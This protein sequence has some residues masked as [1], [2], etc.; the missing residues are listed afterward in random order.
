M[1][2][3]TITPR[4]R[5]DRTLSF[6]GVDRA[7][8]MEIAL[9]EQT[10]ERWKAEGLPESAASADLLAGSAHFGLEGYDSVLFNTTFPEPCP[11]E[12]V[13]S[14]DERYVTFVDGMGR[15]R[16]ALKSGTVRGM[17][18]SMDS[19]VGFP[20][21]SREDWPRLRA[22][23]EANPAARVPAGWPAL[24]ARLR[25]ASRPTT[26]FDRYFATFGCYSMMRNWMGTEGV[27]YMLYDDPALV[28]ECLGFLVDLL[29]RFL[30][31]PL[32]DAGFDLYYIHEDMAGTQGPLVS[33][34]LFREI[35]LPP[36]R[37][38]VDLLKKGGVK[39]VIVDTDGCFGPLIPVFLDAGVDGFGPI[40]RAAGMD[41]R[42]LRARYGKGFSMIGGI[43]KRILKKGRR[44]MEKEITELLPPLLEQGGYIPTIDHSIPPDISL[45]QFEAYLAVKRRAVFGRP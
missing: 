7:P 17:R 3:D 22:L 16:V 33:P 24:A 13:V 20:I 27:S 35:F 43:D 12:T 2:A 14:E 26:F 4:E 18:L 19:Y 45:A 21:R 38:L 39:N 31:G 32:A 42:E 8:F 9:W 30:P 6:Q 28:R 25:A 1:S 36:Y 15:T 44:D 34:E 37:R 5:L 40:E 23:Y 29:G 41:P 10:V 11:P